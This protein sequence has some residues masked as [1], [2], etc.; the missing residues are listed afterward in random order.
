M[1]P[2][3]LLILIWECIWSVLLLVVFGLF[4]WWNGREF[5]KIV[6]DWD[7]RR[8]YWKK[9]EDETWARIEADLN[10]AHGVSHKDSV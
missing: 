9:R 2:E 7:E 5:D 8:E 3:L 10:R 6:R 4:M 1:V